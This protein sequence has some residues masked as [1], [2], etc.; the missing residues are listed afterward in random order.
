MPTITVKAK[1]RQLQLKKRGTALLHEFDLLHVLGR[2]GRVQAIGSYS[3]DLMQVPDVDFKIYCEKL[4]QSAIRRL[5]GQM[6]RRPDVIGI[7][8]LD[9]T[10]LQG[11]ERRGVYLNIIPYFQGELWKLDLLFLDAVNERPDH[12]AL[13]SRLKSLSQEERD[14]ILTLKAELLEIG[15]Y[16]HPTVFHTSAVFHGADVYQAVMEGAKTVAD[17]ERWKAVRDSVHKTGSN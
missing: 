9:F 15:R 8:L 11:G 1:E 17:L 7:R 14:T 16:S 12:T 5:G 3:Y 10:K 4:D 2:F 13:I 6:A